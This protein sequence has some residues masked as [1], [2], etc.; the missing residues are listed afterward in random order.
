LRRYFKNKTHLNWVE[1][2]T[3]RNLA[4]KT[5]RRA[6]FEYER[7]IAKE[8]NSNP[9]QFWRYIKSTRNSKL[10][11]DVESIPI[12][13]VKKQLDR[14]NVSKAAGL[15]DIHARFLVELK[16]SIVMPL[17]TIFNKSLSEGK[18]L[19]DWKKALIKPLFKKG[20]KKGD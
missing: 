10:Y 5:V 7:K 3:H 1:F 20:S 15:D 18:L 9:K 14:L 6:K 13:L 2:T 19:M 4:N 16:A 11:L 17:H 8:V 12:D